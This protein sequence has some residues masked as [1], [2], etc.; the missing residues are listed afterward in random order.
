MVRVKRRYILFEVVPNDDVLRLDIASVDKPLKIT[1]KDIIYA[2]RQKIL[3]L[4]GDFGLGSVLKSLHVK[5]FT[6]ATR[7]GVISVQRGQHTMV[8]SSMPL[9]KKIKDLNCMVRIVRLS[10]T[11]RGCLRYL[12]VY[13]KA[14]V[15]MYKKEMEG[16]K[17]GLQEIESQLSQQNLNQNTGEEPLDET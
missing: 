17:A 14:Q 10:G 4:Y 15:R 11:I 13:Y 5:R 7:L 1:E 9:V 3:Q 12:K 2:F 16:I 6:G 8:T